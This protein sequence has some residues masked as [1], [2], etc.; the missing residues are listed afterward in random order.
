MRKFRIPRRSFLKGAG[1]SILLPA[2]DIM[3]QPRTSMAASGPA[4][5][6]R[7]AAFF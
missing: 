6:P 4:A 7:Y 3:V 1:A 2:L 5:S